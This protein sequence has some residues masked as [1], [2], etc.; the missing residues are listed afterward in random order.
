MLMEAVERIRNQPLEPQYD[1]RWSCGL[2][3]GIAMDVHE[4]TIQAE[5]DRLFPRCRKAV[6]AY[7]R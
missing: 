3:G 2:H 1:A 6:R 4:P 5:H 7:Y